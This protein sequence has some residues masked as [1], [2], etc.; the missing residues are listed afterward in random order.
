VAPYY[1]LP[2]T[3]GLPAHFSH[4]AE[5]G[6]L[7]IVLYNVP[8]RTVTDLRPDIVQELARRFPGTFI[9]IKDASGDLARVTELRIAL[10]ETFC[11][12]SGDDKLALPFNTA[13]GV[14]CISVTANVAPAMC[15]GLQCINKPQLCEGWSSLSKPMRWPGAPVG[16]CIPSALKPLRGT[17]P[18][19][20]LPAQKPCI[21]QS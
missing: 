1:S 6:D 16:M 18:L 12:L 4:L 2:S 14:G 5:H 17:S 19:L 8:S 21:R 15:A 11:Q 13:G 10:G 7:P 9:G 3:A 20:D